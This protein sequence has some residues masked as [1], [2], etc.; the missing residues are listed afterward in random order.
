LPWAGD[1]G[2]RHKFECRASTHGKWSAHGKGRFSGSD[3]VEGE[4][5]G[6]EKGKKK[7]YPLS[8]LKMLGK[9]MKHI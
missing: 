7:G 3:K 2:S 1:A 8:L 5:H 6:Q 4:L 9:P